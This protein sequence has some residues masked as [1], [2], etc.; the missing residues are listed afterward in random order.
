[1]QRLGFLF[2]ALAL[3]GFTSCSDPKSKGSK[4]RDQ[5]NSQ[6]TNAAKDGED[7]GKPGKTE[8]VV[9]KTS[10]GTIELELYPDKAPITVK[11]FLRYVDD[12]FY[13]GT[14]FHRVIKTFMIQGGG[15]TPGLK[16]K[17]TREPIRNEVSN[18]LLN[19]RGTIAMARTGDPDSATAQFFINVVDNSKGLGPGGNDPFGYCVFG[20]VTKGMDVV[21]KIKDVETGRNDVPEEDVIIESVRRAPDKKDK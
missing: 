5:G 3:F 7:N 4:K 18:G 6:D 10:M 8:N 20:K 11:N 16:P 1:M 13:D 19:K 17:K 12:K 9:M 21:D 15:M 2:L 14:I